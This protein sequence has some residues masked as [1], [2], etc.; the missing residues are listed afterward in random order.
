MHDTQREDKHIHC[1]LTQEC[2]VSSTPEDSRASGLPFYFRAGM[3]RRPQKS[4]SGPLC[5]NRIVNSFG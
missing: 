2:T 4:D 1:K 5:V 3:P